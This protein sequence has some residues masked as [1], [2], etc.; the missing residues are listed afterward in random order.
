M[1]INPSQPSHTYSSQKPEKKGPSLNF[2]VTKALAP[3][4][5]K[6]TSLAGRV[7]KATTSTPEAARILNSTGL[8]RLA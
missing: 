3:T 2:L 7:T 4:S 8:K 5:T 1:K 6:T